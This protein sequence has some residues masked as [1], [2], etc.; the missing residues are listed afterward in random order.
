MLAP[1]AAGYGWDL[2][3]GT[4]W[5][6]EVMLDLCGH[7]GTQSLSQ[8][9][10]QLCFPG[11]KAKRGARQPQPP[12]PRSWRGQQG[13]STAG[14]TSARGSALLAAARGKQ[15]GDNCRGV[16][17]GS[18]AWLCTRFSCCQ[19]AVQFAFHV[20]Y[21]FLGMPRPWDKSTCEV[22]VLEENQKPEDTFSNTS[23]WCPVRHPKQDCSLAPIPN[24]IVKVS[25]NVIPPLAAG[26]FIYY[27]IFQKGFLTH[28]LPSSLW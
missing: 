24:L 15:G 16:V 25:A 19:R 28:H 2:P 6:P 23:H 21:R 14:Q 1:A 11:R 12:Q 13:P 27:D 3:Q 26:R 17:L 20:Y 9:S 5:S 8:L 7:S 10:P 4:H 22:A 18:W